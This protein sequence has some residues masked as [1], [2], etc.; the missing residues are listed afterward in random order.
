MDAMRALVDRLLRRHPRM[1][2][3]VM[4]AGVVAVVLARVVGDVGGG[5]P[6]RCDDPLAWEEAGTAIGEEAAVAGPVADV[7][8]APDVGGQPTFVNLGAAHPGEPR[9]D[10][11]VYAEVAEQLD[12]PLEE[13]HGQVVCAV[14]EVRERDGVPQIVVDLPVQLRPA[15]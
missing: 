1:L 11:V 15:R 10:V 8:H 6:V 13:L 5:D 7:T 2:A 4:A 12:H 3:G 9:F 14:G